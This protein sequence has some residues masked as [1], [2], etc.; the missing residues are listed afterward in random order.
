MVRAAA[1]AFVGFVADEYDKYGFDCIFLSFLVVLVL[2]DDDENN[3][4]P[5]SVALI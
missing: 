1:K 4:E 2:D 3:D 5:G